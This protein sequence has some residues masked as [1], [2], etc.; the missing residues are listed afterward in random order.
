MCETEIA[1][2]RRM[3]AELQWELDERSAE[4]Q[5]LTAERDEALK[6][7]AA[8]AEVLQVI[9]SSPGD[10]A[11]VFDAILDKSM[12]LC[13]AAFGGLWNF[14]RGRYL[15]VA[16]RNV[17]TAY[18]EFFAKT[19]VIPGP[20]TA[21]YRFLMALGAMIAGAPPTGVT[22]VASA[23]LA[24]TASNPAAIPAAFATERRCP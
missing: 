7:Q 13:E 2:L 10:L 12:R 4:L 17:P 9:N 21:P 14:D 18:A 15:A 5:R 3:V 16:L 19:T 24:S 6:Q 1:D 8:T 23:P 22:T 20:G 11:P